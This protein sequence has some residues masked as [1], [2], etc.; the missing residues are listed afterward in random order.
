MINKINYLIVIRINSIY[1]VGSVSGCRDTIIPE[2]FW[3]YHVIESFNKDTYINKGYKLSRY[4]VDNFPYAT[5]E[6][7]RECINNI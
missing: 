5:K 3:E 6:Q 4:T 2:R 7:I 1:S